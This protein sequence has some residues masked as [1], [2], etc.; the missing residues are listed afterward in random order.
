MAV[1]GSSNGQL[2]STIDRMVIGSALVASFVLGIVSS[3]KLVRFK[4]VNGPGSRVDNGSGCQRR[5]IGHHPDCERFEDHTMVIGGR[6]RCSGC[7][8]L[9]LGC[10]IGLLLLFL[11]LIDP[12]VVPS[13]GPALVVIGLFLVLTNF[14]ETAHHSRTPALH[15]IGNVILPIGFLSVTI[16]VSE[17]TGEVAV[18]LL[19]VLISYLL[20]E[21]RIHISDWKHMEICRMCGKI[22]QSY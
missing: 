9:G 2:L 19:A 14:A 6:V 4:R 16:G 12:F 20:L 8:G 22:C 3:A 1:I 10:V 11:V 5:R 13:Q 18:G 7:L 21:T 15:I 17:A